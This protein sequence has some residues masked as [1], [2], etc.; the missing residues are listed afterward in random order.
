MAFMEL[1]QSSSNL[2]GES[3]YEDGTNRNTILRTARRLER[4]NELTHKVKRN[5]PSLRH[6]TKDHP[7]F[8]KLIKTCFSILSAVA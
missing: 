1:L 7:A 4:Y 2:D 6:G 3:G 8:G 5:S